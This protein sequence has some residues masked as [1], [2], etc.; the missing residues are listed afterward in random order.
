MRKLEAALQ[1]SSADE[2]PRA[3]V[4]RHVMPDHPNDALLDLVEA[5]H[6]ESR[7]GD[8]PF[9]RV[10]ARRQ[11]NKTKVVRAKETFPSP[12]S[13]FVEERMQIGLC[14]KN[15]PVQ[16]FWSS[17]AVFESEKSLEVGR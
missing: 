14:S 7:F 13:E 15:K 3:L 16:Y 10:K 11:L 8:I 4:L 12:I 1:R 2:P 17:C 9:S 6:R 5:G